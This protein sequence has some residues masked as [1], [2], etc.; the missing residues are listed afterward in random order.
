MNN[1]TAKQLEFVFDMNCKFS[2]YVPSTDNVDE[3]IDNTAEVERIIGELSDMFGGAT[4][5]PAKGGWRCADGKVVVEDVTIV[6]AFCTTEQAT[7]HFMDVYGI[8]QRLCQEFHQE[9]VTLEYNGQV[10]FVTAE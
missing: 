5:T 1:Q 3:H 4:A 9:A 7:D 6:Y 2:V 10:K 8:C